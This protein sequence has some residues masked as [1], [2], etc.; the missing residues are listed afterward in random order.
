MIWSVE[1]REKLILAVDPLLNTMTIY[2]GVIFYVY[3]YVQ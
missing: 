3:L 2:C 1:Y